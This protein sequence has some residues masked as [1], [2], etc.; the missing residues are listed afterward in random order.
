DQLTLAAAM[1]SITARL[2]APEPLTF[3]QLFQGQRTRGAV[4][5]TFLALLEMVR[6]RL[7]RVHQADG[8]GEI[9]GSGTPATREGATPEVDPREDTGEARVRP[10][11]G[12]GRAGCGQLRAGG[13]GGGGDRRAPRRGGALRPPGAEEPE[14]GAG[15]GEGAGGEPALRHRPPGEP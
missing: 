14:D 2:S 11:G 4:V 6:L 1:Q 15:A 3:L 7:V 13:R 10:A 5:V 9:W 12:R 8:A